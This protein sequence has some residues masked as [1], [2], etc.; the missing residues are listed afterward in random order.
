MKKQ[1]L[2][3]LFFFTLTVLSFG[4]SIEEIFKALPLAYANE[5]TLEAK[6]SLIQNGTYTFPG[7]D[8][9]ESLKCDYTSEKDFI[10][11]IYSFPSGQ[12][13]ILI[14]ELRKFEKIDGSLAVVYAKFGGARRAY[15][16][17]TLLTFDYQDSSLR[18]NENLGLPE[19]IEPYQFLKDNLPDSVKTESRNL[20]TSYN[21]VPEE[22]NSVEYLVNPETNQS[23]ELI[24]T[25][26][27]LFTWN[28]VRFEKSEK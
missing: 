24:K 9:V 15:E 19:T 18:L 14:I 8:E 16:Q 22:A 1:L 13:G 2:T 28:G 21:L 5:L 4:Q 12:S 17:H 3:L 26:R 11:M 27:F 7:G 23:E 25:D 20:N 10:R 6:D